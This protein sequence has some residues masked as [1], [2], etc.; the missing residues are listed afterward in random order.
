M[1]LSERL[2]APFSF[3]FPVIKATPDAAVKIH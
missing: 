2:P 3:I 1:P